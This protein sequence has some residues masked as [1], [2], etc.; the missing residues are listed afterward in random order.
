MQYTLQKRR[1]SRKRRGAAEGGRGEEGEPRRFVGMVYRV[2]VSLRTDSTI[3]PMTKMK[4]IRS[5][6]IGDRTGIG[7]S[8]D[9][10]DLSNTSVAICGDLRF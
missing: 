3:Q 4:K 1:R 2:R 9:A 10:F 6:A 7:R 8:K 5:H